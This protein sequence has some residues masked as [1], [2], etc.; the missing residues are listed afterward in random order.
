MSR[1]KATEHHVE[2]CLFLP[3]I[4]SVTLFLRLHRARRP[5]RS[6][7]QNLRETNTAINEITKRFVTQ[8]KQ[9]RLYTS[10]WKRFSGWQQQVQKGCVGEIT[11]SQKKKG[12]DVQ[13]K[14]KV[15]IQTLYTYIFSYVD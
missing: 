5:Q 3:S 15:S 10:T 4:Q 1:Y 11:I 6:H 12:F 14:Y 13:I 7:A 8:K 9:L 2:V